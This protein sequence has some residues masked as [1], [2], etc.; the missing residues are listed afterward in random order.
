MLRY[1]KP[2]VFPV[3]ALALQLAAQKWD[4]L[5][6]EAPRFTLAVVLVW[7]VLAILTAAARR[8]PKV[9][10]WLPIPV[11]TARMS[12]PEELTKI[13]VQ[14]H[15]FQIANLMHN[16][17]LIDRTF[18]DCDIWGPAVVVLSGSSLM[19]DCGIHGT[20]DS[21]VIVVTDDQ[22]VVQGVVEAQRCVFRRCQFHDVA[23]LGTADKV[24]K[25]RDTVPRIY[26]DGTKVMPTPPTEPPPKT[27]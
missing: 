24:Q 17:K 18:E 7:L 19:H 2:V 14:G 10:E 6:T 22:R 20:P 1:L 25:F 9:L 23:F 8:F 21:A 26:P 3:L 11:P 16:G 5:N 12:V 27:E 15:T 13:H 4:W